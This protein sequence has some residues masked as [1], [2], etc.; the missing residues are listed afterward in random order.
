MVHRLLAWKQAWRRLGPAGRNTT[1][2]TTMGASAGIFVNGVKLGAHM[3]DSQPA[4]RPHVSEPRAPL[5]G[6]NPPV[7]G[8]AKNGGQ[9]SK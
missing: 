6:P 4:E 7:D 9:P 8:K 2:M 1:V 5:P 3:R